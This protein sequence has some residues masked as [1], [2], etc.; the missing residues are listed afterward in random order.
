MRGAVGNKKTGFGGVF[1]RKLKDM[2]TML[3]MAG[4][5]FSGVK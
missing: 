2:A 5:T 1:L 3:A 4:I